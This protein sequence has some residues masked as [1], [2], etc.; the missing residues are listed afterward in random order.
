MNHCQSHC[1]VVGNNQNKGAAAVAKNEVNKLFAQ[2][3]NC[4]IKFL[5]CS[6]GSDKSGKNLQHQNISP[7]TV[8]LYKGLAGM[9]EATQR[10][11]CP[12]EIKEA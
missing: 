9:K 6:N 12:S 11:Q 1:Q 10:P 7:K 5:T 2:I 3:N 8:F 4:V